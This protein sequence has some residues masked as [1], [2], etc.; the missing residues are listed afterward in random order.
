MTVLSTC[1]TD[2][3]LKGAFGVALGF[4]VLVGGTSEN[5]VLVGKGV[6]VGRGVSLGVSASVGLGVHVGWSCNGVTVNVGR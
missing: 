4:C 3:A 5:G 2:G 1:V 6:K